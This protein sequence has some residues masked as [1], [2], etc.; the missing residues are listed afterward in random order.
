M[1]QI[2]TWH[3]TLWQCLWPIILEGG[4]QDGTVR[5]LGVEAG[6]YLAMNRFT[7]SFFILWRNNSL[8][9]QEACSNFR[10]IIINH[11]LP[12]KGNSTGATTPM[13]RRA[14]SSKKVKARLTLTSAIGEHF[15][16]GADLD[17]HNSNAICFALYTISTYIYMCISISTYICAFI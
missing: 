1:L 13:T 16:G 6:L 12:E 10:H 14:F 17:N 8:A 3:M 11:D 5:L 15:Y 9:V 2:C 4:F 7:Q